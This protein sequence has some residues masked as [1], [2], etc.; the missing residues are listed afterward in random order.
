MSMYEALYCQ[1]FFKNEQLMSAYFDGPFFGCQTLERLSTIMVS[2]AMTSFTFAASPDR[3]KWAL[4]GWKNLATVTSAD[5]F[6][7]GLRPAISQ[8]LFSA[9]VVPP[10]DMGASETFWT[11]IAHIVPTLSAD[12]ITHSLRDMEI[13]ICKL[14]LDYL[15][16]NGPTFLPLMRALA[17]ILAKAPRDFWDAMGP[18]SPSAIIEGIFH[19]PQYDFIAHADSETSSNNQHFFEDLVAWVR[20]FME[21]VS[22]SNQA[23]ACRSLASQFLRRLQ[24]GRYSERVRIRWQKAGI[25][26]LKWA[27]LIRLDDNAT[28]DAV[29]RA[30]GSD[31]LNIFKE[32]LAEVIANVT[33]R[34]ELNVPVM[35]SDI[36]RE[37]IQAALTLECRLLRIDHQMLS[38]G[39]HL[40]G[41]S[42]R[43]NLD[44]WKQVISVLD[45]RDT[46]LVEAALP[47]TVELSDLGQFGPKGDAEFTAERSRFNGQ[48]QECVKYMCRVIGRVGELPVQHMRHFLSDQTQR[49][50]FTAAL[51]SSENELYEATIDIIKNMSGEAIRQD[52]IRHL[53]ELDLAGALGD[54]AS[55]I[56]RVTDSR[57]FYACPRVLKTSADILNILCDPQDGLLRGAALPDEVQNQAL[58]YW[59]NQWA[60]LSTVYQMTERWSAEQERNFMKEFCRDTMQFSETL[61]RNYIVF[62]NAFN[63]SDGSTDS[64]SQQLLS[65]PLSTMDY[66]IIYLRLRDDYLAAKAVS[67]ITNLMGELDSGS[68][69]VSTRVVAYLKSVAGGTTRTVLNAQQKAELNKSLQIDEDDIPAMERSNSQALGKSRVDARGQVSKLRTGKIDMTA[70]QAKSKTGIQDGTRALPI[71][72]TR[73]GVAGVKPKSLSTLPSAGLRGQ[74]TV[75][76]KE[77]SPAAMNAFM[78]QR[79]R[80]KKEKMH[81]DQAAAAKLR[82][83]DTNTI[84]GQVAGAG[85]ALA[86]L[87]NMSKDHN[88]R[89]TGIL[90]SSDEESEDDIDATL[91]GARSG[92]STNASKD[93]TIGRRPLQAAPGP[94]KKIRQE[95]SAKD[96][97][98]RLSPNLAA[99][100]RTILAWDL[101]KGGDFPSGSSS[102]DYTLVTSSF[103]VPNDYQRTF[104]PLLLLEAWQ[105]FQQ[106][107]EDPAVWARPLSVKVG[108]RLNVD[109]LV[110]ITASLEMSQFKD[111]GVRETDILVLSKDKQPESGSRCL[112]RVQ[113]IGKKRPTSVEI[114][115]RVSPE[116]NSLMGSLVQ[117]TEVFGF[118]I[119]SLTPLEREYGALLGLQYYDLCDEITQA[120]PSPLL[121]YSTEKISKICNMY[122]LNQA[123]AKAVQS[124]MDN[125]AFTLI[126]GPPGSGKTKT[127]ISIVGALLSDTLK[128]SEDVT[129]ARPR[130]TNG[131][132]Q[133]NPT[134]SKKLLVCAPSNAAVDE[135]VMRLMDGV[136]TYS[137]EKHSISVIR[138]GRS[139]RINAKVADVTLDELVNRK[140]NITDTSEQGPDEMKVLMDKHKATCEELNTLH[141]VFDEAHHSG[142][143]VSAE[144]RLLKEKLQQQKR[145]LGLQ[146]DNMKDGGNTRARDADIRRTQAQRDIL[147]SA[148][149]LCAT[150]SGSGHA[151]FQQLDIDFETVIIDEAA[152]SVELSA[153]IPLKYGCQ[154]CIMVGDPK[155][156]PPTVLSREA[157]RFQYEQSLFVRMQSNRPNDVHLLDT[158]Y[159]MHPEISQ[160]PSRAF[161]DGKL[162]DG[163][164]M[165]ALRRKAWHA[166]AYLGPYRFFDVAGAQQRELKSLVNMAEVEGAYRLY[167]RL[168]AV[169]RDYDFSGKVGIITP[170]RSQLQ[171]LRDRFRREFGEEIF[172]AI[173]FNTTDAFQGRE[174]EVIIFSCVRASKQGIGFL[175]DIRRMNVGIT[176]AKCSLW[177]LGNAS[178]LEQGEYWRKLISNARQRDLITTGNVSELLQ[179]PAKAAPSSRQVQPPP[180][181]P[182]AKQV[183]LEPNTYEDKMEIDHPQI[184]FKSEIK[185][186]SKSSL[187][188]AHGV[189]ANTYREKRRRSSSGS[190]AEPRA[191]SKA[192]RTAEVQQKGDRVPS[193]GRYSATE[194]GV[195]T[196]VK[197]DKEAKTENGTGQT[198]SGNRDIDRNTTPVVPRPIRPLQQPRPKP[199]ASIFIAPKRKR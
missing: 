75:P 38:K 87:G 59:S 189:S 96:R 51:L 57:R 106:A 117:N 181:V 122:E 136:K 48:F 6:D 161:Y 54:F 152:Q 86:G 46:A 196:S 113:K 195:K 85:S 53:L 109:A 55:A 5:E 144:Q 140:L 80:E 110:E 167:K 148:H 64:S 124:A 61:F 130:T 56:N 143:Q 119:T 190:S 127:I 187:K 165:A 105:G 12:L 97:R 39:Q 28:S 120:V 193:E 192:P 77:S 172:D 137:G 14:V 111:I 142:R 26:V 90:M 93:V 158:Q 24:N 114:T 84:S 35:L 173:D 186:E 23:P 19:N 121:K 10:P 191:S 175:S 138:L 88:R 89:K 182:Q 68:L 66:M 9:A 197:A 153:L 112:A 179:G 101:F 33:K 100:H 67:I 126:Q 98:A 44:V 47:A 155:Q 8:A 69:S 146:I 65:A 171:K 198:V 174:S 135:L 36:S 134:M 40:S 116:S 168:R 31:L 21:S 15:N 22:S 131:S 30:V 163:A 37:A 50:A 162:L 20:P 16:V 41:S 83:Q 71:S 199:K 17:C 128:R 166:D 73:P 123:Q 58:C 107:R 188:S 34:S 159:R 156:L 25:N 60:F 94:V 183:K 178:A 108:T 99:L 102:D 32:Y 43:S 176:R 185:Q 82:G 104:E 164:N 7:F 45:T 27:L 147:D 115:L 145:N 118:K 72:S 62:A 169:A 103:R 29:G 194:G 49:P 160:F 81:R 184:S 78:E 13:D 180:D 149:V 18:V 177:V 52:A 2:P 157:A 151:M 79:Q 125:D 76:K 63:S 141:A 91:F 139:D 42:A 133:H 1:A 150:L 3:R 70:W 154:K 92:R 4:E 95:R 11:A 74:V 132:A 170:Y 129:I